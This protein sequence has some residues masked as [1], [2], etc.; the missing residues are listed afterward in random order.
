[1]IWSC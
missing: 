1:M